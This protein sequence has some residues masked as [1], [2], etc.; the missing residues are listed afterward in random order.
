MMAESPKLAKP[1]KTVLITD[2]DNTLF[3]W[4][5]LWLQCFSAMLDS[6]IQISGIS[7]EQLIPEIA[8]VHQIHRTS[9]YSFLIEE[10]PSL[11]SFLNGRAAIEVFAPAIE[12]YRAQRRKYLKLYPSVAETLLKIKGSGTRIIAYTESMAFYSN[13]RIRRLGL[14][15]VFDCV[16]SP[17]DHV[18]PE[19][20]TADDVRYYPAQHYDLRYTKQR[21]TPKGSKKPDVDVLN[22]I[23]AEQNLNK[24]DCVYVGDSLMKDVVMAQDCGIVD[25]WAKYGQ[26]HRRPEYKLLQDVTH[27]SP[28]DVKR[29]QMLREREHVHPKNTLEQSF[30]DILALFEFRDFHD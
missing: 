27:W 30:G 14:D 21:H 13:Y 5:E 23:V 24:A 11:R 15:G 9:E 22:S 6:I 18:L 4:V 2:F 28:E 10:L 26:A 12:I 17:L 19:G 3:D 29:E 7:R 8:V 20:I 1:A 25:V 16:F